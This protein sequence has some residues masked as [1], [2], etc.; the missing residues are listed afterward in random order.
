MI[1]LTLIFFCILISRSQAA[2]NPNGIKILLVNEQFLVIDSVTFP[3]SELSIGNGQRP[4][5]LRAWLHA[6][7]KK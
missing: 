7:K 1:R 6:R 4:S 2:G 5:P 3:A